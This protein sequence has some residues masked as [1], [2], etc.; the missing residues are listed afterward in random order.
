[1]VAARLAWH[2]PGNPGTMLALL[3][4]QLHSKSDWRTDLAGKL[5]FFFLMCARLFSAKSKNWLSRMK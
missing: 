3:P 2:C 4:L 1:M 5:P